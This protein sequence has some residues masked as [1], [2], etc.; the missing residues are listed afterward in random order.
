MPRTVDKLKRA[1][2]TAAVCRAPVS[3]LP[4]PSAGNEDAPTWMNAD[5]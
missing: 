5:I 3:M 2:A 4:D 1:A